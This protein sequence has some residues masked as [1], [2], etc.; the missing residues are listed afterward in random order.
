MKRMFVV[1]ITVIVM[2]S[3][4]YAQKVPQGEEFKKWMQDIDTQVKNF[5]AAYESM[6]LAKASASISAL[7]KD[8]EN[9]DTHFSK[10]QKAD[11]VKWSK[12]T[13]ARLGEAGDKLKRQD[14][15]YALNLVQLNQKTC[16][17]CHDVY[18]AAPTKTN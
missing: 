6:D 2:T 1:L 11:A 5:T 14:I 12:E 17:S 10:A 8:F 13:R 9:V 15:S 7:E 16:K 4:L 18:R 3:I